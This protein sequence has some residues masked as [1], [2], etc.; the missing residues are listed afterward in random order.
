MFLVKRCRTLVVEDCND[1]D[2]SNGVGKSKLMILGAFRISSKCVGS[3]DGNSGSSSL[4]VSSLN[5]ISIDARSKVGLKRQQI[6][7]G[8]K[9]SSIVGKQYLE[10]S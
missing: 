1:D 10:Y 4:L 2:Q 9:K 7:L 8:M 3:R 5:L 6:S